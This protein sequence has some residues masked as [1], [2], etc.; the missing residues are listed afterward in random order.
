MPVECCG[1]ARQGRFCSECGK[2]LMQSPLTELLHYCRKAVYRDQLEAARWREQG[3][4]DYAERAD[5]RVEQK[6]AWADA[7]AA[8]IEGAREA[9][10]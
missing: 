9:D 5:R 4:H 7:L 1:A 6:E 3:H 8:L 10:S 2:P